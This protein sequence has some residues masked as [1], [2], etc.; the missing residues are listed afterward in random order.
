MKI[1]TCPVL[2]RKSEKCVVVT[3]PSRDKHNF[4]MNDNPVKDDIAFYFM[5][6][7]NIDKNELPNPDAGPET[8]RK[9]SRRLS[10]A[11]SISNVTADS[12]LTDKRAILKISRNS[13]IELINKWK[14]VDKAQED[15][16]N[17]RDLHIVKT[18]QFEKRWREVERGQLQLK[19]NLVKFNNFVKEKQMKV[20]EGVQRSKKEHDIFTRKYEESKSL[21]QEQDVL[22]K[23][24]DGLKKSI[25]EK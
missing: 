17:V 13:E 21:E 8:I 25:K 2:G 1:C 5:W 16:E 23:A 11:T 20:E 12:A 4:E 22:M 15:L 18:E 3:Q 14:A 19:Q 24:K 6:K 10:I 9:L 7:S